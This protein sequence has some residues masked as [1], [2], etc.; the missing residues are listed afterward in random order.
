L[1]HFAAAPNGEAPRRWHRRSVEIQGRSLTG[2]EAAVLNLLLSVESDGVAELREQ[3]KVATV[4]GRCNCGC[5]SVDLSVGFDAPRSPYEGR[6]WP[7][8][9]QIA[10]SSGDPPG[11]V[12]LFLDDGRLSYLECVW[13]G[14]MAPSSWPIIESLSTRPR[15][16]SNGSAR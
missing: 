4:T 1:L 6:L 5:P 15:P 16:T 3:A 10:A 2:D 9:G 11:E 14:E 12:L 8:E 7:V 13:Y